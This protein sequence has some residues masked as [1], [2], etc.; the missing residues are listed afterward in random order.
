MASSA[1]AAIQNASLLDRIVEG[2]LALARGQSPRP[3][4]CS[5][6]EI[7]DGLLL[8]LR[9]QIR[10]KHVQFQSE[11]PEDSVVLFADWEQVEQA[12]LNLVVNAIQAV[13]EGGK[14]GIRSRRISDG[15][16]IEVWDDGPGIPREIRATL[17]EAF[18]T[19]KPGGL[20]LGLPVVHRI[21][22]EHGGKITVNT[23]PGGG[24]IFVLEF[25]EGRGR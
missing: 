10:D 18:V 8:L 12:L 22:R 6:P 20:G 1:A 11:I 14:V 24:S 3:E 2:A 5:L 21:V 17:F 15:T 13:A 16:A 7:V 23:R 19:T 25:P 4:E 9:H